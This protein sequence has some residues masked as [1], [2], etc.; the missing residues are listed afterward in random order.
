VSHDHF[1]Q[2]N[3]YLAAEKKQKE[4]DVRQGIK[5]EKPKPSV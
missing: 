4:N 5:P 3:P 2:F 1:A